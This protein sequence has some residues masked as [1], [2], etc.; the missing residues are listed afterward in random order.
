[1]ADFT[2]W[3]GKYKQL[4]VLTGIFGLLL[5]PFLWPFFLAIVFNSLTLLV[6]A[7]LIWALYKQP[8]KK[9]KKDEEPEHFKDGGEKGRCEMGADDHTGSKNPKEAVSPEQKRQEKEEEPLR[10][11]APTFPKK[12]GK[13][14]ASKLEKNTQNE[15][16]AF[17][18]SW[19]QMQG[20]ETILRFRRKLDKESITSFSIG[21]DGICAVK[22]GKRY[23]RIGVL[24][25]FPGREMETVV[26]QL[27]KDG[28]RASQSKDHRY[29][30]VSWK[31]EGVQK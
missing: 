15:E 13:E 3:I 6:P 11:D 17:A 18:R 20:R 12:A 7:L 25:D 4:C 16:T 24:R 1:M 14:D 10:K 23:R 26:M 27:K 29:L 19:Y 21:R 28:L 5:S 8:W 9:K 30:W 2:K 31:R 22:E